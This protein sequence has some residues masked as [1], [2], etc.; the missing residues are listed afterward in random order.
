MV[1]NAPAVCGVQTVIIREQYLKSLC[2]DNAGCC[3]HHM[4]NG[5]YMCSCHYV[6]V[7]HTG[8]NTEV[9][10]ILPMHDNYTMCHVMKAPLIFMCSCY[11]DNYTHRWKW[12]CHCVIVAQ[13]AIHCH[14]VNV[15]VATIK[16]KE[17][18]TSNFKVRL[19]NICDANYT[20]K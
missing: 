7:T 4:M 18:I 20:D 19:S 2:D 16:H 17:L 10:M 15:P 14:M 3:C 8:G 1:V 6:I 13:G 9:A 12:Y 5:P 11:R